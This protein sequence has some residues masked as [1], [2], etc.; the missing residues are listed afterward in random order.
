MAGDWLK[1]RHDLH[2]DPSVIQIAAALEMPEDEVVGKL[3]RFWTWVDRQCATE[4][5]TLAASRSRN[6]SD[7]RSVTVAWLDRYVGAPGFADAMFAAGWLVDTR[8]DIIIPNFDRHLSQGA[9]RRAL[10]ARRNAKLRHE[11]DGVSVTN[12]TPGASRN[13][14]L[15]KEKEKE[16]QEGDKPP[17]PPKPRAAKKPATIPPVLDTSAF[18]AAWADYTQHRREK[19]AT[20]TATAEKAAL[21]KLAGWGVAR[22][23]AALEN[24]TAS[25]YTGI[26]EPDRKTHGKPEPDPNRP[27]TGL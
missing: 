19:R 21:K 7:A 22:A 24:S 17:L 16:L 23:V 20:M 6:E 26:I 12:V 5:V 3:V 8:G 14:L 27:Y 18:L 1:V 11:R 10:A 9:K 2:D 25:G 15:E 13:E 4:K